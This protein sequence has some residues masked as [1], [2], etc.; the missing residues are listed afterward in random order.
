MQ[1]MLND[2]QEATQACCC[3]L[4]FGLRLKRFWVP[5]SGFWG[6]GFGFSEGAKVPRRGIIKF[7]VFGVWGVLR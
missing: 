1:Q 2:I 3:V 6:L 4:V 7:L 5:G